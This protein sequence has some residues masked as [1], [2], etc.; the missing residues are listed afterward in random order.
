MG[1]CQRH[2]PAMMP[3]RTTWS[4]LELHRQL[5]QRAA[6]PNSSRVYG[7]ESFEYP[8]DDDS[9]IMTMSPSPAHS[10]VRRSVWERNSSG[11]PTYQ[12]AVAF[13]AR[14]AKPPPESGPDPVI[15][16]H[17]GLPTVLPRVSYKHLYLVR[18]ILKRRMTYLRPAD[19]EAN[20]ARSGSSWN[21]RVVIVNP[22]SSQDHGGLPGHT[23]SIY[24]LHLIKHHMTISCRIGEVDDALYCLLAPVSNDIFGAT[25]SS[26]RSGL[27]GSPARASTPSSFSVSGRDWLLSA[28]RDKTMRLW[29]M[30]PSPRVVKVFAGGHSGSIL[31][32]FVAEIPVEDSSSRS[33]LGSYSSY[34]RSPPK[35]PSPM[36]DAPKTRLIAI[37]G[38]GDGKI[39]LWDIE[40][41]DG[42][43]EKAIQ[44]HTD[45]VFFV[46]GDDE[47]IVS[48]SKGELDVAQELTSD[49]TIRV[50][51]IRTLEELVVIEDASDGHRGAINAVDI[52]KE[53]M[54]VYVMC[55]L[56]P[57]S[58]PRATARSRYG[59]STTGACAR[60]STRTCAASR[61]WHSSR[62]R[63]GWRGGSPR[64]PARSSAQQS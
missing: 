52:S 30:S 63:R 8:D 24:S 59:T 21:P 35:S 47:K 26:S 5:L 58:R 17:L 29:Q 7:D 53:F 1:L 55:K 6:S 20:G 4:D 2:T 64:S 39:C 10:A 19:L 3:A 22:T 42:T 36:R 9:H 31:T 56:T 34:A 51:D 62:T 57:A 44:A 18:R 50:F 49:R 54:Y 60:A 27:S 16:S 38:G 61:R 28:S 12:R 14:A 25:V 43:P 46:R 15:S 37:S 48:C 40:N 45:S 41:G 33:P 11:L 32:H 23:E 13:S